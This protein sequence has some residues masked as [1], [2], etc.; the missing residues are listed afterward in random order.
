[1]YSLL[2]FIPVILIALF[3]FIINQLLKN[4]P[5]WSKLI[6]IIVVLLALI[7]QLIYSFLH[8]LTV[9]EE[10]ARRRF[11]NPRTYPLAIKKLHNKH[12]INIFPDKIPDKAK[13]IKIEIA[14][15]PLFASFRYFDITLRFDTTPK[16]IKKVKEKYKNIKPIDTS[17]LSKRSQFLPPVL[18]EEIIKNYELY[19]IMHKFEYPDEN[20][21]NVFYGGIAISKTGNRIVYIYNS[22]YGDYC[23][24]CYK[25]GASITKHK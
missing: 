7:L 8:I 17:T 21:E 2:A 25:K 10:A 6:S 23:G 13:N 18:P 11:E 9:D 19:N 4:H 15:G 16:Y 12:I 20:Y 22:F 3:F 5:I 1:L 14:N 24:S